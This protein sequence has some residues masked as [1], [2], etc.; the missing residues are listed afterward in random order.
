MNC[1]VFSIFLGVVFPSKKRPAETHVNNIPISHRK[2]G[3]DFCLGL[4][5]LPSFWGFSTAGHFPSTEFPSSYGCRCWY[6]LW[7][8]SLCLFSCCFFSQILPLVNITMKNH[9]H[10]GDVF[11]TCFPTTFKPSNKSKEA[12][13]ALLKGQSLAP[14][15]MQLVNARFPT[16]CGKRG[17]CLKDV[18]KDE[19]Y[20]WIEGTIQ[21]NPEETKSFT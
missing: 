1:C 15:V 20:R 13:M 21:G 8:W 11:G 10:F 18:F 19:V 12:E 2:L 14:E 7:Y 3:I 5:T 6:R 16:T 4:S 17:I 9:H